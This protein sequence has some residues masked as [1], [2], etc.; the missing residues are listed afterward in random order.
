MDTELSTLTAG[1]SS[2]LLGV[3]WPV[4]QG[5]D[6]WLE[7]MNVRS[8]RTSADR[9]LMLGR[10]PECYIDERTGD[11]GPYLRWLIALRLLLRH[12]NGGRRWQAMEAERAL[13]RRVAARTHFTD[14]LRLEGE[15]LGKQFDNAFGHDPKNL[16]RTAGR[17]MQGRL[18]DAI[19][20]QLN[21]SFPHRE[22][23]RRGTFLEVRNLR[24]GEELEPRTFAQFEHWLRNGVHPPNDDL[25]TLMCEELLRCPARRREGG[26]GDQVDDVFRQLHLPNTPQ[27]IVSVYARNGWTGLRAF[28]TAVLD[29]LVTARGEGDPESPLGLIYLRLSRSGHGGDASAPTPAPDAPTPTFDTPTPASFVHTLRRAFGLPIDTA[30]EGGSQPFDMHGELLPIRR[31]LT[32]YRTVLVVDGLAHS[33]GP[34]AELFDMLRDSHWPELLR[35]LMQ[36]HEPTLAQR[37][38]RYPSRMLV[39]SSQ[40]VSQLRPWLS[41]VVPLAEVP[42]DVDARALLAPDPARKSRLARLA[43]RLGARVSSE[44]LDQLFPLN[45]SQRQ[46][47]F[48]G[49]EPHQIPTELDL[50]LA[51]LH[52]GEDLRAMR[53][54]HQTGGHIDLV[55]LRRQQLARWMQAVARQPQGFVDL[56]VLKMVCC[57]VNGLRLSTLRRCLLCWLE[58]VGRHLTAAQ[59]RQLKAFATEGRLESLS[60]RYPQ[61]VVLNRD[62]D[63]EAI[64]LRQRRFELQAFPDAGDTPLAADDDKPLL[65]VRLESLRE[66]MFAEI[67]RGQ[68]EGAGDSAPNPLHRPR[69]EWELINLVL[70]EES[71]RQATAQL[72]NME[73]HELGTPAVYRRLVQCVYH[74]LLSHGY[75]DRSANGPA[76]AQPTL[77]GFTLPAE[78]FRRFRYLYAFVF[79]HCIENAPEWTL[80]RGFVRSEM[81]FLLSGMFANPRWGVELL[82]N[83]HAMSGSQRQL[84]RARDLLVSAS[85][86]RLLGASSTPWIL[87]E[88]VLQ[89]DILEALARSAYDTGRHGFARRLAHF[90]QHQRRS[91]EA[92]AA[93]AAGRAA[94]AAP[95][96]VAAGAETLQAQLSSIATTIGALNDLIG[97][98]STRRPPGLQ[99]DPVDHAF[100]KLMVDSRLSRTHYSAARAMCLRWLGAHGLDCTAF[101]GLSALYPDHGSLPKGQLAKT[102]FEI[103]VLNPLA[104]RVR[105]AGASTRDRVA[106][107]DMLSRLGQCI[108]GLAD[109]GSQPSSRIDALLSAYGIFWIADR[110]R[111]NASGIDDSLAWPRVSSKA[112]RSFIR[113]SLKIA[114]LMARDAEPGSPLHNDGLAFYAQARRR[115]DVY[116]SHLFRLPRERLAMLLLMASATRVWG[117][118]GVGKAASA[119][120]ETDLEASLEYLGQAQALLFRL[121]FPDALARRFFFERAKTY[122][123]LALWR[124]PVHGT[125]QQA[126]FIR[127][128]DALIKMSAEDP[129]WCRLAAR[130]GDVGDTTHPGL[131]PTIEAE[132]EE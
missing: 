112:M 117:E 34:L 129:F 73:R 127:D 93:A 11:L 114:R 15:G 66:L 23:I 76:R 68:L 65:D 16:W 50:A 104:E 119:S 95:S 83:L 67:I 100:E 5:C 3:F 61:L 106:L 101:E 89:T 21:A 56:L 28:A 85:Y 120:R 35:V 123:R 126:L 25:R 86:G 108:A 80:S 9:C 22:P 60:E 97:E 38:G 58:L 51:C 107:A 113:V 47:L 18:F 121:G 4:E 59:A 39:L 62:G 41:A 105:Q 125:V 84:R 57:S 109:E 7:P 6:D 40:P 111:S 13:R 131:F 43:E 69:G 72:R 46:A 45:A 19:I 8:P 78:P 44:G 14:L 1:N 33:E 82:A 36:P 115:M 87:R 17:Y 81:R 49:R 20:D 52:E 31:A 48:A 103:H 79:R 102:A 63:V 2:S 92:R 132:G 90:V 64:G 32:I 75:D 94:L 24:E 122:R 55:P 54:L 128:R 74:G 124:G 10:P 42:R 70:A 30:P 88:N 27:P 98:V 29:E 12:A 96:S 26:R 53:Q 118:I 71:L 99:H 110:V 77:P 37:G 130:L 91:P 116:T